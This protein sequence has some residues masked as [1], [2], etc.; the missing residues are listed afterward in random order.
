MMVR[1]NIQGSTG[2]SERFTFTGKEKDAETGYGYFGARYMDHELMTMWLSVDPLAD[3]YP[4]ISPY[5]YCAWSPIRLVDPDGRDL[6]IGEILYS[7]KMSSNGYDDFTKKA[8]DAL[9]ELYATAE[10]QLMLDALI[11]KDIVVNISP[12]YETEN[13]LNEA[14]DDSYFNIETNMPGT[15]EGFLCD[16]SW[17]SIQSNGQ[18]CVEGIDKNTTLDLA[19]EIAHAYDA[20]NGWAYR[21]I[22]KNGI[23]EV[24]DGM[25][26]GYDKREFQAAYRVNIISDQMGNKN[27][28]TKYYSNPSIAE[29]ETFYRPCWY[30]LST[31]DKTQRI[32]FDIP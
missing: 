28:R 11:S 6:W 19:D 2:H 14:P 7:A 21:Y 27:Y 30:T 24:D 26:N 29:K 10:G 15:G 17:N 22:E 31:T 32:T 12:G 20:V 13:Y 23:V 5:A 16:I 4:S 1:H 18:Q 3:K 9:N 8:I 25:V